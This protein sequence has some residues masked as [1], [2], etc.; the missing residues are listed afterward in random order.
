MSLPAGRL[1]VPVFPEMFT[2]GAIRIVPE[3]R[4]MWMPEEM[5]SAGMFPDV[6]MR[7]PV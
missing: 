3:L 2:Q 7:V 4:A 6:W 1:I 5:S